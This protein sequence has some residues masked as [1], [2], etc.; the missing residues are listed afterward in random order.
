MRRCTTQELKLQAWAGLPRQAVGGM[1]GPVQEYCRIH[2]L[3]PLT[4]L[5][6][7]EQTGLPGTGFDAA[8]DI[9]EAQARVFGFDWASVDCPS[10]EAFERAEVEP[11]R[12]GME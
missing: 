7:S 1:L 4:V 12:S 6:V 11:A 8:E 5:V 2:S 10:P 3:P 9:P